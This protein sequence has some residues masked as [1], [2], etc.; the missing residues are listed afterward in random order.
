MYLAHRTPSPRLNPYS[1]GSNSNMGMEELENFLY[2][3]LNP[4]STGS[5][6]NFVCGS[7]FSQK[8]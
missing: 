6:S 4:Y 1:T 7:E 3:R 5:N 2:Q 8:V